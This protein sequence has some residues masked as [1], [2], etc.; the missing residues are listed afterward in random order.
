MKTT[1]LLLLISINSIF[2]S[3]SQLAGNALS[4]DASN[5]YCSAGL[6]TVFDNI[7]SNNFTIECWVKPISNPTSKR[8][9]FAQK[10]ASNFCSI[11]MNSSNVPYFFVQK[12][13]INYSANT[14]TT[15]ASGVWS[16]LAFTWS[17]GT[18]T[19]TAF[20]NGI[21]VNSISGGSSSLG[22]DGVMTIGARTDGQQ[23]FSG[24]IDELR[25]WNDIRT[26]CEIFG[27]R[28]SEF[29]TNQANLVASYNF[30][31][32]TAN[33]TNT[34]VVTLS[35]LTN[36][37]DATL[38]NFL[39]TGTTSNWVTSGADVTQTNNNSETYFSNDI[40]TAC[41]SYT[42][43]NGLTYFANNN[44]ATYTYTN[45]TTGCTVTM[46]LDLTIDTI[47]NVDTPSNINACDSYVLPVLTNGTYYTSPNGGGLTLNANDLI[48]SS[49]TL[50]IYVQ[51]GTCSDEHSFEIAI[52]TL[53]TADSLS[54][55]SACDNY[56]LPVL[57]VGSYFSET[58]GNG[59]LFSPGD[60]IS[61]SQ[62]L[63]VYA[64]NGTC[65]D[66]NSFEIVIDTLVIADAPS[67][68][69]VCDNYEL[70]VLSVGSY[71]SDSNGNGT[72]FSA[73]DVVSSSQTLYVYAENGT[74]SDENSFTITINPLPLNTISVTNNIL[75]ADQNGA[76]YQWLNCNNGD[77]LIPGATSQS[78]TPTLNGSYAVEIEEN[79]CIDTSECFAI[80]DLGIY[81]AGT[82][83]SISVYPNPT[84]GKITLISDN[85][86]GNA[87]MLIRNVLGQVVTEYTLSS[88]KQ[89][90]VN[91][92]GSEGVYFIEIE[93]GIKKSL[94]KVVKEK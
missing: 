37:Y 46:L 44:S 61:S 94:I 24:A 53:V 21:Q 43:T 71:F 41:E 14:Q 91:L 4:F 29:T 67:S 18:N 70:P 92:E 51:N 82:A 78:F 93:D 68:V 89:I 90:E 73:G 27:S 35:D 34:G 15:L 83:H 76:T 54:S 8:I 19:I 86:F 5:G 32:G 38:T 1:I 33:A 13:G 20:I 26:P 74:C 77:S 30:N 9:F 58:D 84:Q 42:W 45:S 22:V 60:I 65:S 64:E 85:E 66:E 23:L 59:I 75:T 2:Y 52:D 25:I 11:L 81:E 7:A 47:I 6:P 87:T 39:L 56:E 40:I 69:S 57:L 55:V 31:H 63:Y 50:Y 28:N 72:L 12:S 80:V 48:T 88:I 16:H 79:G 49:Q 10:N 3:F 17:P 62:T 36:N